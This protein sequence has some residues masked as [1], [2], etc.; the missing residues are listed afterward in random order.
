[1]TM[2]M[3]RFASGV[4]LVCTFTSTAGAQVGSG[5]ET[6]LW[7]RAVFHLHHDTA[8]VRGT[9]DFASYLTGE[10]HAETNFNPR[11]SRLGFRASRAGDAW[12][13]AAVFELDFYGDNAGNNLLPRLR[14]GYAEFS[15]PG[16]GFQLRAGQDWIPIA[17]QNPATIDF[18]IL[19]WGGNLWWRVPQVTARL[20]RGSLQ[21][22][23]S[24][25]KHRITDDP[26]PDDPTPWFLCR[27]QVS[28]FFHDG[29]LFALGGGVRSV[30]IGDAEFAPYVVAA[31]L[32]LPFT[33][34]LSAKAEAFV[35]EGLGSHFIRYGLDFDRTPGRL[36][37]IGAAGGFVSAG[38]VATDAW[39]VNAGYGLDD[40]DEGQMSGLTTGGV[41][42]QRNQVGFVN[43]QRRID[44]NA[45]IGL[46][47]L[48]F[49]TDGPDGQE[50]RGQRFT[51][52]FGFVF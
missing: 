7:G 5:V 32:V 26:N 31:E 49:R 17:Q 20:D 37:A 35:G 4:A 41:P 39:S 46:E 3:A 19:A 34:A 36:A 44:A 52:S 45:S 27:V 50:L 18:G 51:T 42:F 24:V 43:V 12:N 11:D 23:A 1:M 14:L 21:V 47:V 15:H 28:G 33:P 2:G 22:L 13:T 38:W 6:R 25:M 10:D 40:P 9:T 8:D 29:G 48:N 16:H 30:Q